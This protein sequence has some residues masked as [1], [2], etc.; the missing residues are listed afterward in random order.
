MA[1]VQDLRFLVHFL[2]D[3]VAAVFLHHAVAVAARVAGDGVADV[4]QVRAGAHRS[5]AFPHRLVS[6][7]HQPARGVV[8]LTDQVGGAGVGDVAVLLRVMSRLT[9]WP[10]RSTSVVLGTPWQITLSIEALST[11]GK[12]YWPLLAG[13][14]QLVNDHAFDEIVDLHRAAALQRQLV[15]CG[16]HLGQQAP[17]FGHQRDLVGALDDRHLLRPVRCQQRRLHAGSP[18]F[19]G[20]DVLEA[21]RG[22]HLAQHADPDPEVGLGVDRTAGHS[23]GT[24]Q[25]VVQGVIDVDDAHRRSWSGNIRSVYVSYIRLKPALFSPGGWQSAGG[26]RRGRAAASRGCPS[27]CH[28]V[29]ARSARWRR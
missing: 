7:L 22:V 27:R 14:L 19:A 12:P 4:A 18:Q 17:G 5:D 13:R 8:D 16:E 3:A 15:E 29:A 21:Q 6:G 2:A 26:C 11:Y 24:A 23:A 25:L 1:V 28:A 10:L 9:I 20:D